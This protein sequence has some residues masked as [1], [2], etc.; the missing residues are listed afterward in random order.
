MDHFINIYAHHADVYHRM[1]A[2]EDVDGNLLPALETITPFEGARVLDIGSGTGR[3]PLLIQSKVSHMAALDLH[4]GMLREQQRQRD[5]ISG[6]WEMIQGDLRVL[7]CPENRFDV[8]T[9][10]WVIGHFTEW[11]TPDWYYQVDQA[12]DEMRR[13][14]KP[15]GAMV[16]IETLSTGSTIPAPPTKRLTQYYARLEDQW[17][18][19]RQQ[20][21][22]DY[23]FRDLEEAIELSGFFFGA[24]LAERVRENNWIRL[25][26]WTG[27][28]S[29]INNG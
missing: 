17:R 9:A 2:A 6:T 29:K 22:T 11:Y 7:P 20:I 18:F 15:G 27:V 16:I 5:H 3:I 4:Q 25:P 14:L 13:V 12:I 26:E 28:W 23:I 21:Q 24:K 19:Q 8:V 10:G 1:I